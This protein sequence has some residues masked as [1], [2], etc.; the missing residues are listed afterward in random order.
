MREYIDSCHR[1]SESCAAYLE[2]NTAHFN[3]I[4][5]ITANSDSITPQKKNNGRE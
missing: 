4:A 2:H 5:N 3:N 1:E